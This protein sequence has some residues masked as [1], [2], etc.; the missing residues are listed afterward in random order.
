MSIAEGDKETARF[1]Y[2]NSGQIARAIRES[3][4]E[5]FEWDGLALIE[6]SGTKYVNEPHA[7]GGNPVISD[8]QVFFNDMLGTT[9]GAVNGKEYSAVDK[10]AFGVSN[11][12]TNTFFTGKPYV[13]DLGYAFLF[14]NYQPQLGKWLTQDPLGYPDGW[15]NFTYCGNNVTLCFDYLGA[16][17]VYSSSMQGTINTLNST[18]IGR[19]IISQL[20]NSSKTHTI[21][22]S[23]NGT[24]S[25]VSPDN[26]NNVSNGEGTGSTI[27]MDTFNPNNSNP[28]G[29]GWDRPYELGV[30]HELAEAAAMDNGNIAEG[31]TNNVNNSE[32]EACKKTN[33]ALKELQKSEPDIYDQYETRKT[34]GGSSLPSRAYE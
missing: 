7:G 28:D 14:R 6:R 18:S 8:G 21:T 17:L 33:D 3:N 1:E 32:I 19:S 10:T 26:P 29:S 16:K 5:T 4:V 25:V 12:G 30:M 34:Y 22:E 9:L 31:Q 24:G 15:N 27:K 13:K 2:H 20:Q 11:N 23:S